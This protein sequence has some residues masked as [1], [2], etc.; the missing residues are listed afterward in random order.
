ML[1]TTLNL[2]GRMSGAGMKETRSEYIS[3]LVL[4][5]IYSLRSLDYF[6]I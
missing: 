2:R 6:E 5:A 3:L 4:K 1:E